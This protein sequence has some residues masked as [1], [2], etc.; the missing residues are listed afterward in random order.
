MNGVVIGDE[1][2]L[3]LAPLVAL[4]HGQVLQDVLHLRAEQMHQAG[5]DVVVGHV[6][7][8]DDRRWLR[9]CRVAAVVFGRYELVGAEDQFG[10]LEAV[11]AHARVVQVL[12]IFRWHC[13]HLN[14]HKF[15]RKNS[16]NIFL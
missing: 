15:Q 3:H 6:Q 2:D 9:E 5:L 12:E 4:V 13:K 7:D 8:E 10:S 1:A 11:Y 16:K 14:Q